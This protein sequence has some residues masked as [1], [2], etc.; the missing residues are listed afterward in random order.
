LIAFRL[1]RRGVTTLSRD[2]EQFALLYGDTNGRASICRD[3]HS[4]PLGGRGLCE[5]SRRSTIDAIASAPG[6]THA[7]LVLQRDALTY[8][9]VGAQSRAKQ[10][11]HFDVADTRFQAYG[12]NNPKTADPGP[13]A[14]FR[15]WWET[16]TLVGCGRKFDVPL[17]FAPDSTGT[18]VIQSV[19]DVTER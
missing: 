7:D 11:S 1:P 8:A 4:R 18:Q 6:D 14:R 5:S 12:L 19:G 3:R 2:L 16:W 10:C 15:P 9:I 17:S 13:S